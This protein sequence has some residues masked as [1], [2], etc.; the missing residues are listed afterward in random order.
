MLNNRELIS[1]KIVFITI[2]FKVRFNIESEIYYP[3]HMPSCQNLKKEKLK[4]KGK[5]LR[6]NDSSW[7]IKRFR[8]EAV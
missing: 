4:G 2:R 1:V 7:G 5:L 8:Y 3:K 6:E